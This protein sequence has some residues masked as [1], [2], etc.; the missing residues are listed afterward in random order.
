MI[1]PLVSFIAW[2]RMGLTAR[3][4]TAML[5]TKDDFQL[6][7]IDNNSMDDTWEY[8]KD[9]KDGRIISRTKFANNEGPVHAVNY[10]L[11]KRRKEQFFIT[12]DND[13][14]VH[15]SG[16]VSSFLDTFK[17][18]SNLGLLGAVSNEYYSR[19]RLPLVKQESEGAFYLQ[20]QR[21][22]VEGCCQCL[23]PE[24]L[25]LLGYWSEENC[26]GDVEICHRIARYTPYKM[27]FI[28][29]IEI[30]QLQS[31]PCDSCCGKSWCGLD[32]KEKSCFSI[33]REKYNNPRFRNTYGW[34]Y[35]KC[36]HEM[37]NGSREIFCASIHDEASLKEHKY[38][39]HTAEENFRFYREKAN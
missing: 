39:R 18:F 20:V 37:E 13:V 23:K 38:N 7:I 3:N 35:E 17:A 8:I 1:P 24:L 28:P 25:E 27:G 9:L 6:H 29:G 5:N 11:S 4:L 21:G 14:N 36:L 22:F 33:H 19:Y 15:T 30:D 34:K 31:V 26:M 12:V 16:W 10:N 2:N 32:R